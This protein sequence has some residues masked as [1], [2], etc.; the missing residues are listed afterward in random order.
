MATI[1]AESP[2][3]SI[4]Q[5]VLGPDGPIARAL[6]AYEPRRPQIDMANLCGQAIEEH[7]HALIEAGTGTG[8]SLGYLIPAIRSGARV[9]VST[10]TIQL[11]EQLVGKDLPFLQRVLD[12][13]FTFAIAKGR[14]NFFCERN[15]VSFLDEGGSDLLAT[16][17]AAEVLTAF[18]SGS[19]SGDK[20]DLKLTLRDAHWGNISGDDSCTGKGCPFRSTCPYLAAKAAYEDADVVVTNHAMYLL[21]RYVNEKTGGLINILP[22]HTVWVADEAHTLADKCVDTWGVEIPQSRPASFMKKLRKQAKIL[23]IELEESAV[24][25]IA[26]AADALFSY[27]HTAP[28][29]QML[30]SELPPEIV[31]K[32]EQQK[33]KLVDALKPVRLAIYRATPRPSDNAP[34][35]EREKA[36]ACSRLYTSAGELIDNLNVIFAPPLEECPKCEGSGEGEDADECIRCDGT[37]QVPNTDPHVVYVELRSTSFGPFATLHRKPIETRPIFQ[38]ILRNLH[39]ALFTSAT[40]TSGPGVSGWRPVAEELGLS[41]SSTLT[42]QVESPFDYARQVIGYIPAG[43]PE[44]RHPEYHT[45][46]ADEVAR[47]LTYTQG[48]AFILFTARR[49]M[50]SVANLVRARVR[51]PILTQGEMPKD[52]LVRRFKDTP[53]SVLFGVKTFWAGVDIPGDALSCVVLVKLPFPQFDH[54][55]NKARCERIEKRGSS[56]FGEFHLPRCI[57]DVKQGFGRLIRA[58]SDTG[59]FAIL[60]PRMHSKNYGQTIANALPDFPVVS[61]L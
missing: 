31:E 12:Q 47:I 13:P 16:N 48:Q 51:F 49:D 45:Q 27:F 34:P 2:L 38:R 15:A 44:A 19:W 37:G 9:V 50:E 42:L 7:R 55:L 56:S 22:A 36:A 11:Q 39:S 59:V 25:S 17:A 30:L 23:D 21:D 14:G 8:K 46:I 52:E 4:G 3:S 6:P 5:E 29:E 43:L 20:T 18:R 35:E 28:K 61:K 54:P 32:A 58:K 57:R 40:L 60:D 10:D 26:R 53:N 24:V 41:L 1:T 33:N